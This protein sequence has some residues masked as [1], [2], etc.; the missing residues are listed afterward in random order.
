VNLK[1]QP[2]MARCGKSCCDQ[3][4]SDLNKTI[5]C[6][7][8]CNRYYHS[9]CAGISRNV[10]TL[11]STTKNVLWFCDPCYHIHKNGFEKISALYN[12]ILKSRELNK[13]LLDNMYKN[14]NSNIN[15][16]STSIENAKKEILINNDE[17]RSSYAAV[18]KKND[19]KVT[20]KKD[21]VVII[22][23]KDKTKGN[24]KTKIDIKSK[25]N[26]NEIPV[27]GLINTNNG[28]VIIKCKKRMIL[29][30]LKTLSIQ[31]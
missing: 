18:L 29:K 13:T 9:S 24:E 7:G 16:Q 21:S 11:I 4:L 27:N 20:T 8:F 5:Q 23:P 28:G 3:P 6:A 25:I 15:Q 12:E 30:K 14:L 19:D 1:F 2:K 31:I 10:E 22:R 17:T 26:P